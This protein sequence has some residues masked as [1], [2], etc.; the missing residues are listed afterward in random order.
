MGDSALNVRVST[1]L[2]SCVEPGRIFFKKSINVIAFLEKKR[3]IPPN[4][5][6]NVTKVNG[7]PS[8]T[9]EKFTAYVT[10]CTCPDSVGEPAQLTQTA[11]TGEE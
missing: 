6:R 5:K 9:A 1:G 4:D 7:T 3:K 2:T 10:Q 8:H 11:A